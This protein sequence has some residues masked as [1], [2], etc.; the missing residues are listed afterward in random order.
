MAKIK[1]KNKISKYN[2]YSS[3]EYFSLKYMLILQENY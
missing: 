1:I 3:L 2:K